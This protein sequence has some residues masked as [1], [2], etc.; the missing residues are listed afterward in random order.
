MK[1]AQFSIAKLMVV[2]GVVA[3]NLGAGRLIFEF[4]PPLLLVIAPAGLAAQ[5]FLFRLIRTRG[6]RRAFWAGLVAGGLLTVCSFLWGFV[7]GG[8]TGIGVDPSTG[9]R[10]V[11][12][13]PGVAGSAQVRTIWAK[14]QQF[15][16]RTLNTIAKSW[17]MSELGAGL[18]AGLFVLFPMIVVGMAGGMLALCIIW[19]AGTARSQLKP[20]P[21]VSD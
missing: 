3:L 6:P 17:N 15:A 9:Q 14:Y 16:E 19:F 7:F 20:S 12:R 2:V 11:V 8:S 4:G 21:A 1:S 10:I 13:T 5:F 18:I